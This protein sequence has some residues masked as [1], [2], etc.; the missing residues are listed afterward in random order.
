MAN[1]QRG[2]MKFVSIQYLRIAAALGVVLFHASL[3][4]LDGRAI[5]PFNFGQIG[6]DLFFVISGFIIYYTTADDR[7][8]PGVFLLRRAIR[9]IP[10]YFIFTTLAL[11]IVTI[12]PM[13]TR[14][15][16]PSLFDYFRS[17]LFIPFYNPKSLFVSPILSQGWTLNYEV[18]YYLIFAI[19]LLLH[20]EQ[21]LLVS[22]AVLILLVAIHLSIHPLE[23]FISVYTNSRLSEFVLGMVIAYTTKHYP[24]KLAKLTMLFS[25]AGALASAAYIVDSNA[26]VAAN[27]S[28]F[29]GLPCAAIVC[30]LVWLEFENKMPRIPILILAGDASY[31]LYLGH[32]F[33]LS[34]LRRPWGQLNPESFW[35]HATFMVSCTIA[36]LALAIL[37]FLWVERPVTQRLMR[38]ARRW[39]PQPELVIAECVAGAP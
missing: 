2:G 1:V 28:I 19:C 37:T 12:A 34:I 25:A 35:T 33:V 5:I 29:F 8:K 10:M 7:M 21:R 27:L 13:A 6:V 26:T 14:S 30:G 24:E 32:I 4:L 22:S 36:S 18:F 17:I 23:F 20:R 11:L 9:I 31:S 3:S 39:Q 38:Y 15:I 16:D